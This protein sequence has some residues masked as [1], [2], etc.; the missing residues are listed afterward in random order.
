M[1]V[2]LQAMNV[3]RP[4]KALLHQLPHVDAVGMRNFMDK[5]P[6]DDVVGQVLIR[7]M[8]VRKN[9]LITVDTFMAMFD[10]ATRYLLVHTGTF[11]V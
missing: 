4:A 1:L 2:W 7:A 9:A 11:V 3:A 8:L 5:Q 6:E 10:R